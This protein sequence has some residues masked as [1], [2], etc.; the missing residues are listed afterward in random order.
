MSAGRGGRG[1]KR[2]KRSAEPAAK[3]PAAETALSTLPSEGEAAPQPGWVAPVLTEEFPGL[4][5]F[6]TSVERGSGRSP[7]RVK[8]RLRA[9][10]DRFY[11]S[12]AVVLR[13]RPIPAAY[14]VFFRQIGL[15]PDQ[16]PTPVEQV[17]LD[18]MRDGR[19]KSRNLLDD[20][21]TIATIEIGVAL[22]ALD[23]DRIE[24]TIGLRASAPGERFEG[25]QSPLAPGTLVIADE[26]R[27]LAI[28]F[29]ETAASRGVQPK[30]KRTTL[31][32]I[33]V[34]GVP[35]VAVEEALWMAASTMRA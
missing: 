17:A 3:A 2:K 29:G 34:K 1:A 12:H 25:R 16:Q 27:P 30:T 35:D 18:R 7:E 26:A 31:I 28:L 33:Q 4:A 5:L 14:R 13:Q 20:A 21:L 8:A 24:G 22:R 32:A 9:L 10:S 15:D 23:T 11:G 6:H 19:F